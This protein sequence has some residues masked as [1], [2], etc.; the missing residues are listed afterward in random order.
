M[1]RRQKIFYRIGLVLIFIFGGVFA[2]EASKANPVPREC[3]VWFEKAKIDSSKS[4]AMDCAL[5]KSDMG[6]FDCSQFC[7]DL[8]VSLKK[9]DSANFGFKVS[10][11]YPGLTEAEK[12]FVDNNPQMAVHAYWLSWRAENLCKEV[13]LISDTNDESDACPFYLGSST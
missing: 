8:C 13:Y 5:I 9:S 10:S 3:R 11:L 6:T 2:A 1:H 4:C 12:Q 7:D